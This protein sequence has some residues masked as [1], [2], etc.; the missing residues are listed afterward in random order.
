[1]MRPTYRV[2][3][4]LDPKTNEPRYV[5]YGGTRYDVMPWDREWDNRGGSSEL[6]Q[7]LATLDRQPPRDP[8]LTDTVYF[9]DV[10]AKY[11][12]QVRAGINARLLRNRSYDGTQTGGGAARP[13]I[14]PK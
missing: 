10:A 8:T 7:W 5:G 3:L 12:A 4:W 13:V 11:A 2:W 1:M 6:S 14:D 9:R